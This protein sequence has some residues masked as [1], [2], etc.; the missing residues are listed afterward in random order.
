MPESFLNGVDFGVCLRCDLAGVD[1]RWMS[2]LLLGEAWEDEMLRLTMMG[3]VTCLRA[4]RRNRASELCWADLSAMM[5]VEDGVEVEV[6]VA[7]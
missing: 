1:L 4:S 3:V 7:F 5:V 2:V 6:L